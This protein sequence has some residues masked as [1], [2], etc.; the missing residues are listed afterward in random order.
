[1]QGE[2]FV[3]V[4]VV[5]ATQGFIQSNTLGALLQWDQ[6]RFRLLPGV[7]LANVHTVIPI[8]VPFTINGSGFD[9]L[10]GVAVD[11]FCDYTGGKIGPFSINPGYPGPEPSQADLD[12][13]QASEIKAP[14][15]GPG[16][17][18]MSNKGS[19][20]LY[21]SQGA[22][23]EVDRKR[24]ALDERCVIGGRETGPHARSQS[25]LPIR[26]SGCTR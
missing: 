2:R 3:S 9:T 24:V 14:V 8:G 21:S 15:T 7:A 5:N 13:L 6:M 19:D 10:H 16:S 17:L 18:R 25:V 26:P 4:P 23:A 20:G 22:S 12:G 1:M 11:L